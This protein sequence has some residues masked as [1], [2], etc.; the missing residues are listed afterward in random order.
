[1]MLFFASPYNW[2]DVILFFVLRVNCFTCL[3]H[4]NFVVSSHFSSGSQKH[5]MEYECLKFVISRCKNDIVTTGQS[6]KL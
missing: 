2:H 3:S 1:M 5:T 6:I 4:Y